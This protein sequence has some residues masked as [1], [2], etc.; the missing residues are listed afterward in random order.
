MPMMCSST[1]SAVGLR[2]LRRRR[3]VFERREAGCGCLARV[4]KLSGFDLSL[5]GFGDIELTKISWDGCNGPAYPTA[6][7]TRWS[8]SADYWR[9][10]L[11]ST[12]MDQMAR[13]SRCFGI[14]PCGA[15]TSRSPSSRRR[16]W[17]TVTFMCRATMDASSFY[18]LA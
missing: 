1:P 12:G 7:P 6:M 11:T 5:T 8:Q 2:E 16:S 9:M 17:L 4:P 18:G 10:I 15:T 14:V 13:L 3:D